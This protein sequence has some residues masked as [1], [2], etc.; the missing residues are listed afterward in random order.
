MAPAL[1]GALDLTRQKRL[2]PDKSDALPSKPCYGHEPLV[3][4]PDPNCVKCGHSTRPVGEL[5]LL[6]L[7]QHE[8]LAV[9]SAA[10]ERASNE[11]DVLV[12]EQTGCDGFRALMNETY[13]TRDF[14]RADR[15]PL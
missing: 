12:H 2:A 13:W 9:L 15:V 8:N 7:Q 11:L 14:Q 3:F 5:E 6:V 4:A 1:A 10:V